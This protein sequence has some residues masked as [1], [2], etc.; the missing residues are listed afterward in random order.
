MRASQILAGQINSCLPP[1][2]CKP[3]EVRNRSVLTITGSP[4]TL[5]QPQHRA[6][7]QDMLN[8]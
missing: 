2:D 4:A 6:G 8:M 1:S 5:A 3:R 7:T